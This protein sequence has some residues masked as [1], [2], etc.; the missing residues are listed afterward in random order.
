[1]RIKVSED[2]RAASS[3]CKIKSNGQE[4]CLSPQ[5]ILMLTGLIIDPNSHFVITRTHTHGNRTDALSLI[6]GSVLPASSLA[7]SNLLQ[8]TIT[9]YPIPF[10]Q[11]T[12]FSI[13]G[14]PDG[15]V[16][17]TEGNSNKIGRVSGDGT[18]TAFDVPTADSQVGYIVPGPDNANWFTERAASKLGR[19]SM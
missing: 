12:S 19:I 6:L 7:Q 18:I 14:A 11:G 4:S 3:R 17:F 2:A 15:S 1:M 8:V 10:A 9:E 13:V 16:W 5:P